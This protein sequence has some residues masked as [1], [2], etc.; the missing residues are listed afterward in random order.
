MG[1]KQGEINR[2]RPDIELA[3]DQLREARRRKKV[4][5]K[6]RERRRREFDLAEARREVRE[7]DEIG[8]VS[9][10]QETLTPLDE[11]PVVLGRAPA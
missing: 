8:Q 7:A 3:R 2:L 4:M 5:E 9:H 11:S 1:A 10:A 6:L